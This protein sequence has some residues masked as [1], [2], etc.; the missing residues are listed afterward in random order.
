MTPGNRR[1]NSVSQAQQ[2]LDVINAGID[3]Q[4][5]RFP[6]KLA[7]AN[8]AESRY[9]SVIVAVSRPMEVPRERLLLVDI[10]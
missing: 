3:A 8:A 2:T 5:G 1:I 10:K 6:D 4:N 7:D 9:A